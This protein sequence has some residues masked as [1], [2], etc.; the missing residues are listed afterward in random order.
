MNRSPLHDRRA[1]LLMVIFTIMAL[2]FAQTLLLHTHGPHDH[3]HHSGHMTPLEHQHTEIHLAAL[4]P[5][6]EADDLAN[7]IDLSAKGIIKGFKFNH[8]FV[9]VL[10]LLVVLLL[11]RLVNLGRWQITRPRPFNSHQ[12][13]LRPPLRAPPSTLFIQD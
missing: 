12:L 7:E 4:D 9:A 5:D 1:R 2:L 13:L 8:I 10:A 3:H 11:P 6:V